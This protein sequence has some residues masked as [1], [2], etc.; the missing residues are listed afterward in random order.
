MDAH[1]PF[2]HARL[3]LARLACL[4]AA[5]ALCLACLPAT[6]RADDRYY[7][8]DRVDIDATVAT[9]GSLTVSETRYFDFS[10]HFNG[11]YW[12]LPKGEADGRYV[13]VVVN[14]ISEEPYGGDVRTFEESDSGRDYTYSVTDEYSYYRVKI[15]APHDDETVQFTINYTDTNLAQRWAD[16]GELYWKFVSDGWDVESRD[17]TCTVHLPVPAG[18]SVSGGDNVRAW[19]HGPLDAWLSF[20][21]DGSVV[22]RVPGVGTDEYAEAR[23]TF[24][25]EWLSAATARSESRLSSILDEEQ[26]W[27]DEAN[28][29][30]ERAKRTTIGFEVASVA[31][32]AVSLAGLVR[33]WAKYKRAHTPQFQD[34]YFRDVPTDDHPAVLGYLWNRRKMDPRF[35]TAS[36][37][38][39]TDEGY[40][41]LES[42]TSGSG[43]LFG[44]TPKQD[45]RIS[46]TGGG[47]SQGNAKAREVDEAAITF[48]FD[49]LRKGRSRSNGTTL[50]FSQIEEFA[51]DEPKRYHD[52]YDE[53]TTSVEAAGASRGYFRDSLDG[54]P[55][56]IARAFVDIVAAIAMMSIALAGIVPMGFGV[57]CF[58]LFGALFAGHVL[59]GIHMERL[60]QEGVE[61]KAKLKALRNWLKDFT[62]LDEA[63]PHDVVLWNRLLVMAVVLDVADEVIK[64]LKVVAPEV[65]DDPGIGSAYWWYGYGGRYG[66]D[67]PASVFD[68]AMHSAHEVSEAAL[69]ASSS[70]SGGGGGGGFSGG[71]GGGFGGGGGGGAF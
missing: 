63:V 68:G 57:V 56:I 58:L 60:S 45:Y 29:R 8:I 24:P 10:G 3:A 44:T 53:W 43:G 36:L 2:H 47:E 22:Y 7:S 37:M 65:L 20:A 46:L 26:E 32:I 9:D 64:Q 50:E 61:V 1:A 31:L 40:V 28:A 5:L 70:S 18:E 19:G 30:R 69:A 48:L 11:V 4:L 34:E 14:S 21:D 51:N 71:G 41:R 27:A 66:Y 62:S 42:R 13:D 15:Y 35:L 23:V 67:S 52:A 39:L 49:G 6:A 55:G 16:T 38:R 54:L 17:V 25:A 12:D 33:S 59:V